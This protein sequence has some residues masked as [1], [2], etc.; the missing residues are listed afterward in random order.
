[1]FKKFV[2]KSMIFGTIIAVAFASISAASAF[3]ASGTGG[4]GKSQTTV[5]VSQNEVRDVKADSAFLTDLQKHMAKLLTKASTS[6]RSQDQRWLQKYDLALADAQAI[7]AGHFNFTAVTANKATSSSTSSSAT[8]SKTLTVGKYYQS[9]PNKLL[10]LY[11]HL[12]RE[13]RLKLGM[14]A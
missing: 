12:M 10:A 14:S 4:S 2:S 7:L 1:M 6:N 5:A 8:A 9:N 13:L 11:L 3:A